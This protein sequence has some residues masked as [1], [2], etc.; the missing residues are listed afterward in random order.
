MHIY[1]YSSQHSF[2][3][4]RKQS[5]VIDPNRASWSYNCDVHTQAY[6]RP[7]NNL[8]ALI[9]RTRRCIYIDLKM[10]C[11]Q[12]SVIVVAAATQGSH[13]SMQCPSSSSPTS[14]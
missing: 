5:A 10:Y 3:A 8:S 4:L 14:V 7:W 13:L 6:N 1:L 12:S 2:T 11:I 9:L